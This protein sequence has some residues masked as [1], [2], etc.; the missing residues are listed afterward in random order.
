MFVDASRLGGGPFDWALSILFLAL[1]IGGLPAM[2]RIW[3][4]EIGERITQIFSPFSAHT[5]KVFASVIPLSFPGIL[6]TGLLYV[7]I[8]VAGTRVGP[9]SEVALGIANLLVPP[10][11]VVLILLFGILLFGR[12][13]FVIPPYVR[14][15]HGF[16]GGAARHLMKSDH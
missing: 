4:G 8:L 15:H 6:L 12:P 16:L 14:D 9:V 7:S 10:F 2:P 3:R 11:L 13:K 5:R 1:G